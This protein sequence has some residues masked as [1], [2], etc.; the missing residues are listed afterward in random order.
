MVAIKKRYFR[1]ILNGPRFCAGFS[2]FRGRD[3]ITSPYRARYIFQ[4]F[5]VEFF[6]NTKI[7]TSTR[8][9]I[10]IRNDFC[11]LPPMINSS[12][13]HF[14]ISKYECM[15]FN[16]EYICCTRTGESGVF[17]QG[18]LV[19]YDIPISMAIENAFISSRAL[20]LWMHFRRADLPRRISHSRHA[21]ILTKST[22]L[23]YGPRARALPQAMVSPGCMCE[24]LHLLFSL[25]ARARSRLYEL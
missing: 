19:K 6:F 24:R 25:A 22:A 14:Y 18:T 20:Y 10:S 1:Y 7:N 21:C 3:K 5:R 16:V 13:L 9:V 4:L 17:V 15:R 2:D 11:S 12:A 8:R 23:F